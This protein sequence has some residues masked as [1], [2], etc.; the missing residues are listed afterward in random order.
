MKILVIGSGGREHALCWRLRRDPAVKHLWCAPGNGGTTE[1]AENVPIKASDISALSDFAREKGADLTVV[2]P[3]APLCDGIVD[4]FTG[5]GLRIFGPNRDAARLEGSKVFAKEVMNRFDIPTARS[6][7]FSDPDKARRFGR[8]LG[9]PHVVKADGLAAGKGAIIVTDPYAADTAISQMMEQK[10]FGPAG[11][12]IVI[13]EFLGGEEASLQLLVSGR[14][15]I[16]LPTSQDHKRV[17]DGDTGPNTGGM[18]AYSPAPVLEGSVLAEAEH[19]IVRPLLDGLISMGIDYRGVLYIGLM[20]GSGGPKVLEFNC[21]LGDPETQ[22]LMP[23]IQGDLAS[24]LAACASGKLDR[25]TFA[26]SRES[27]IC[28]VAAAPGYPGEY[29]TG[30]PISGLEDAK[31]PNVMIFHAGTRRDGDRV[32]TSGGRVLSVTA[33]GEDLATAR[34]MAYASLKKIRFSGVHYR[35]DIGA[36]AL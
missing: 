18:G 20:I 1:I 17:G 4:V 27:A 29:P 15:W 22:V 6:Q 13:E 11:E 10:A 7:T 19:T 12:R 26:I 16:V 8:T 14:D 35:T 34:S 31:A 33:I 21:R 30:Q 36:R 32:L 23:R 25:S 28:V 2:G 24:L 3:E 5:R 9:F